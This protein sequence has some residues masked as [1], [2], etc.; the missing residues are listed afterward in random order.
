MKKKIIPLL[1]L[2]VVM[3]TF[4]GCNQVGGTYISVNDTKGGEYTFSSDN[5]YTYQDDENS[6]S[7]SYYQSDDMISLNNEDGKTENFRVY[8]DYIFSV[9]DKFDTKLL[10][11]S[12]YINQTLDASSDSVDLNASITLK[13]DGTYEEFVNVGYYTIPGPTG[14]YTLGSNKLILTDDEDGSELVY[15]IYNN[16]LYYHVYQKVWGELWIKMFARS[17]HYY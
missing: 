10:E 17:F 9:K 8:G 5:S 4:V 16:Q 15:I 3:F 11:T 1:L 7:G 12:G 13:D 2:C 6:Y 14:T